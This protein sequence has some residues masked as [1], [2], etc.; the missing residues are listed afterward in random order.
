MSIIDQSGTF[1]LG[2]RAVNRLGYGA[3][4]LAGPSVFGP[5]KDH[6]PGTMQSAQPRTSRGNLD[7]AA[8]QTAP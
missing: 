4:Q 1:T 8:K 3:M 7:R 2:D 5:P 6:R